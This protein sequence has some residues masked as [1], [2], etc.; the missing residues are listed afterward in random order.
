YGHVKRMSHIE[1]TKI[2]AICDT[3]DEVLE[4]SAQYLVDKGVE[5][6]ALYSGGE[7]AY[8][9]M[10]ARDDIDIVIISTPWAWHAPMAIDTMNSAKHAFVEVP[11]ALTVDEMWQIVDTAERTQKNCMMM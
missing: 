11:L 2:V 1:G 7:R 4:R 10:L 6:P 8:Q 5:K 3:H 9:Q